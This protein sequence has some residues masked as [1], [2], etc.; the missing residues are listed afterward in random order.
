MDVSVSHADPSTAVTIADA[1]TEEFIRSEEKRIEKSA[2]EAYKILKNDAALASADVETAQRAMS[3]YASVMATNARIDEMN[4][5]M[6]SLKL[7]CRAQTE[8]RRS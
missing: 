2:G 1:I 7:R 4:K 6:V 5:N 8:Y 3:T